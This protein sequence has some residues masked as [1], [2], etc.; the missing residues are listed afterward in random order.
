MSDR[1]SRRTLR[2]LLTEQRLKG[3]ITESAYKLWRRA[4]E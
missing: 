1:V 3:Y 4:I 2:R